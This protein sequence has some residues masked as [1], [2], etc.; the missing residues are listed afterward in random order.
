[1]IGVAA[2]F[3]IVFC[4]LTMGSLAIVYCFRSLPL[5]VSDLI[6]AIWMPTLASATAGAALFAVNYL[7][8]FGG[9]PAIRLLIDFNIYIFFYILFWSVLP[10]GRQFMREIL[11]LANELR[12][13]PKESGDADS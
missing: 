11:S 12:R 3:S 9:N 1:M 13:K 6:G 4:G 8:L 2:A 5:K 10:N 7:F